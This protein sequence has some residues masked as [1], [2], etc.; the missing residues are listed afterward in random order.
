M[1]MVYDCIYYHICLSAVS[2]LHKQLKHTSS[3]LLG[4]TGLVSA[5]EATRASKDPTDFGEA[6]GRVVFFER[7]FYEIQCEKK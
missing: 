2:P 5:D 6:G 1:Y 4:A 3:L 7:N